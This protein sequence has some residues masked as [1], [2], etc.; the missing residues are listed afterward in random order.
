MTSSQKE[1]FTAECWRCGELRACNKS[2]G[3]MVCLVSSIHGYH[4]DSSIFVWCVLLYLEEVTNY[5]S[6]MWKKAAGTFLKTS[7][8]AFD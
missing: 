7:I 2:K 1:I 4:I 6:Y 8:F 5:C 3:T